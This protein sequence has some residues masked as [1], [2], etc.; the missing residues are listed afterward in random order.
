MARWNSRTVDSLKQFYEV[1]NEVGADELFNGTGL[2][3]ATQEN[4]LDWFYYRKVCDNDKFV[5]FFNREARINSRQFLE[6]LRVE[7]TDFDPVVTQYLERQVLSDVET[8]QDSTG[9]NTGTQNSTIGSDLTQTTKVENQATEA[10][11]GTNNQTVTTNSTTHVDGSND[12]TETRN[13]STTQNG[14]TQV[15]TSGNEH[16]DT[17]QNVSGLTGATPQSAT[18]SNSSGNMPNLDWTY[19]SGQSQTKDATVT[20]SNTTGESDTT[21]SL[22]T[23]DTGTVK[24]DGSN[25][26]TTT[27]NGTNGTIGTTGT[28]TEQKG[29][30]TTTVSGGNTG[31]TTGSNNTETEQFVKGKTGSDT[32]ERLTGRG[33]A[34]QDL[35]DSARNYI[36]RTNAFKWLIAELE[37]CFMGVYDANWNS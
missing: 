26:S 31:L 7:T 6:Y 15:E 33:G 9:K 22:R 19:T 32:R 12:N 11:K 36:L 1:W 4:I 37:K 2:D 5:L 29:T 14:S 23:S 21:S 25:S 34:P 17:T 18:Y 13:L 10:V 35:L 30:T 8:Q 3:D 16:T 24:N 28:D 27:V 20:D